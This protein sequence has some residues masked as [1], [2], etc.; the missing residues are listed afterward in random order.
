LKYIYYIQR[1]EICYA[2]I[3]NSITEEITNYQKYLDIRYYMD[4]ELSTCAGDMKRISI[5]FK[6]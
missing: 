5:S 3:Q 1:K 2:T 4:K 6:I